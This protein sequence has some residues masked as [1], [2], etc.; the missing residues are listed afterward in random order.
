M[1]KIAAIQ[2]D[3]VWEDPD[4]NQ[5]AIRPLVEAAVAQ[6]AQVVVLSE[7]W[8]TGFSMNSAVIAEDHDGPIPT[9]MKELAVSSGAWILGSFPERTVGYERPTNRFLFAGPC[10]E[11]VRYSKVRPFS[12]AGEDQ[13]YSAGRTLERALIHGVRVMPL[14]CYDLRFADLFWNAASETDCFIV[15]ANWPMARRQHWTALLRARAIENQ[16]YVVGVNRIGSGGGL[17]YRGDTRIIDP[18]GDVIKAP[19]NEVATI[20]APIDETWVADVRA[21]FPFMHDR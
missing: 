7:M 12:F 9:F 19:A 16:A 8:A 20:Q 3:I 11:D 14:V 15:V 18:L 4:A 21:R 17:E 6:G 5:A 10:G 1:F 2:H 13:H